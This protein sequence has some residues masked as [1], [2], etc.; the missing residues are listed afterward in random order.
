[1]LAGSGDRS[2]VGYLRRFNDQDSR[3]S[4]LEAVPFERAFKTIV[5]R[6]RTKSFPEVFKASRLTTASLR[7]EP[8]TYALVTGQGSVDTAATAFMSTD[9]VGAPDSDRGPGF[10]R[11][12]GYNIY[13]QRVDGALPTAERDLV[14]Q[15]QSI[16]NER[17]RPCARYYLTD[18]SFGNDCHFNHSQQYDTATKKAIMR[19]ARM[20]PCPKGTVCEDGKCVKGH[21][22][23]FDGICSGKCRFSADMHSVQQLVETTR[24]M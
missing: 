24:Y 11:A 15:I 10:R 1:M 16:K 4:L 9:L 12:I 18:C 14:Q 19:L 23:P 3:I 8:S 17:E 13:G 2:Y 7:R 5:E 6:F 22:C 21:C 20:L